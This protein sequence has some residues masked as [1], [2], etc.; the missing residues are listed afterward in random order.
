MQDVSG[1]IV[2]NGVP[3]IVS[4]LASHHHVSS[5]GEHIDNLAFAFVTPLRTN[6]NRVR[7]LKY[8]LAKIFPTHLA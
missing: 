8:S 3:G 1:A 6:Q 5:G 4:S 2:N 7:H